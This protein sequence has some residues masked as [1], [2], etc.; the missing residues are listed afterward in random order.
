MAE[1]EIIKVEIDA[2]EALELLNT[3]EA[4]G[5]D[6]LP[7]MKSYGIYMVKQIKSMFEKL[8]KGGTHRGVSWEWFSLN[9]Y[10]PNRNPK[11]RIRHSGKRV[12]VSSRIMTDS[13][14]LRRSIMPIAKRHE[15]IIGSYTGYSAELNE[16]RPFMFATQEDIEEFRRR[17]REYLVKK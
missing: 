17:G 10:D 9:M 15:L 1:R 6:P 4:R 12:T 2:K 7:L 5:R 13:G 14:I 8:G 11:G 3:M 16:V